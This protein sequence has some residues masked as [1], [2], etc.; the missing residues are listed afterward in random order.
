M[1]MLGGDWEDVSACFHELTTTPLG[2]F[3]AF[4]PVGA[5]V[6]REHMPLVP[7]SSLGLHLF[8]HTRIEKERKRVPFVSSPIWRVTYLRCPSTTLI[9]CISLTAAGPQRPTTSIP[10]PPNATLLSC[11]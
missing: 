5:S 3:L 2:L 7:I 10:I 1:P 9:F 11:L 8:L 6:C 4:C